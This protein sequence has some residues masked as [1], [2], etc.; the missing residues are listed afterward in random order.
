M[1]ENKLVAGV[2][3]SVLGVAVGFEQAWCMSVL[4][5]WFAVPLGVPAVGVLH[6]FGL[7]LIPATMTAHRS[8]LIGDIWKSSRS[9][10]DTAEL[11]VNKCA[12][13]L[14]SLI[15]LGC[16]WVVAP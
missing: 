10:D 6:M 16:G 14:V 15:M 3:L 7:V 9:G 2:F 12:V 8:I 5:G 4:W 13:G 11:I 1:S